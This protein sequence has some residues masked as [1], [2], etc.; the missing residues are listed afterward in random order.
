M[1]SVHVLDATPKPP[2]EVLANANKVSHGCRGGSNV[3][4]AMPSASEVAS[5]TSFAPS[6]NFTVA[7]GTGCPLF[8]SVIQASA[9][10]AHVFSVTFSVVRAI[11]CRCAPDASFPSGN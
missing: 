1:P 7:P 9:P 10:P 6:V 3:T 5:R 11:N 4:C 2:S 8:R